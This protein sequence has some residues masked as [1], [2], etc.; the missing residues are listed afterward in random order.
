MARGDKVAVNYYKGQSSQAEIFKTK[1]AAAVYY[2][3]I[4]RN[5]GVFQNKRRIT[6][7]TVRQIVQKSS[8]VP[9]ILQD[10][11]YYP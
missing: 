3:W 8:I 5:H 7:A 4:E 6:A 2:V 1:L 9:R 10:L 11:N